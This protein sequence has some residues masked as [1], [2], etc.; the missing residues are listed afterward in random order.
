MA[1]ARFVNP[2]SLTLAIACSAACGGSSTTTNATGG[3]GGQGAQAGQGGSGAMAGT[4][5]TAGMG[6]SGGEPTAS[7]DKLDVLLLVDNSRSMGTFQTQLSDAVDSLITR[8]T[9]PLCIS[10]MDPSDR[11]EAGAPDQPCPAGYTRE[12]RP[13]A[14]LNVGVISSSLGGVGAQTCSAADTQFNEAQND[15]SHLMASVRMG[16]SSYKDLGFLAW[17]PEGAREGESNVGQMVADVRSHV[18]ASG[19]IGCGFEMGLESIYRFLIDPEPPA[20]I[21]RGPCNANDTNNQCAVPSGTDDVLLQQRADFLRPDSAVVVL[22][23]TNENDCSVRQGGQFW[24]PLEYANNFRMPRSSSQCAADPNDACC[25][26]CGASTPSGCQDGCQAGKFYEVSDDNINIRCF[27]QKRRFGIDFLMPTARYVEGLTETEICPGRGG[28]LSSSAPLCSASERVR[29]PLFP[30]PSTAPGVNVRRP[31][32]VYFTGLVGV[33]FQDLQSDDAT[34]ASLG[35]NCEPTL[36][37]P[38]KLSYLTAAQLTQTK[39]WDVI[40]GDPSDNVPPSDPFMI[41]SVSPR[42]G[43]NPVSGDSL[44]PPSAGQGASAINGHEYIPDKNGD[45]QYACISELA[46]PIDCSGFGASCDCNL[47]DIEQTPLCQAA[48]GTYSTF[49]QF[50]TKAYPSTRWLEV[51]KG[52]GDRSAV[53]SVC[54]KTTGADAYVPFV[55][56]V[57]RTVAPSLR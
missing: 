1:Y 30:S 10:N 42:S 15:R 21:T 19:E 48:D 50:Y 16:L 31:S 29:N 35:G 39:R 28:D 52:V 32:D 6:G 56:L 23:I 9:N 5:G 7:R 51:M 38:S 57:V 12:L 47:A 53:G 24:I 33:P 37:D 36:G 41:E 25:Y 14:D 26:S 8:F 43:T 49:E 17:D 45:L 34:C 2:V 4:A 55:D 11:T 13:V 20:S 44:E 27:D 3:Q 40:L 18:E 22:A 46:T 54:T